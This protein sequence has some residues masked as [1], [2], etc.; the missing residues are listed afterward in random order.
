MPDA[1]SEPSGQ[2]RSGICSPSMHEVD[3][4]RGSPV[5]WA[6]TQLRGS[7]H[8]APPSTPPSPPP[9]PF[10]EPQP[11][12]I[13]V[14]DEKRNRA[15]GVLHYHIVPGCLERETHAVRSLRRRT[16]LPCGGPWDCCEGGPGTS[17]SS[18]AV[19][20]IGVPALMRIGPRPALRGLAASAQSRA[21]C[22]PVRGHNPLPT[23]AASALRSPENR[24]EAI[25]RPVT[26]L[27]TCTVA[28][29][30][31]PSAPTVPSI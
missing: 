22:G 29:P 11:P 14:D 10:P 17:E 13:A 6:T 23:S 30:R 20:S 9:L 18:R 25:R 31:D 21:S 8:E 5:S 15:H 12:S 24:S 26:P 1:H 16:G 4:G 3:V 27:R 2:V 7:A 19:G 28:C